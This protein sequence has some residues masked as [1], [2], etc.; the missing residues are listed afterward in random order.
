MGNQVFVGKVGE[1]P[2]YLIT[3]YHVI[4]D[5]VEYGSGELMSGI[6]DDME[7]IWRS[8]IR[9]YFDSSDYEEAYLVAK[10]EA[11]DIAI[12]NLESATSKRKPIALC[13]PTDELIGSNVYAVGYPGLLYSCLPE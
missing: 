1:N 3:N 10:D 5:Y 9:I 8:K 4:A 2:K 7:V 13:S 6:V 11:K 12:L